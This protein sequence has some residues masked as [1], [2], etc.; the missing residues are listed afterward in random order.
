MKFITTL[1]LGILCFSTP[2]FGQKTATLLGSILDK[3]TQEA[4]IGATIKIDGTDLGATT[5]VDGRFQIPNISPKTYSMTATYLGYVPLTKFNIVLSVGNDSQLNFELSP[6]SK[7]L[8]E[9]VISVNK[10]TRVANIET[11]LSIQNLSVEEIRSNPGGNFDISKVVQVLPGIGAGAGGG[12]ERNDL[13]I[14]GGGPSENVYYLDGVEIPVINHFATQ[15]SAGGPAGILNVSFLEDVTLSTSAFNARYDNALSGVLQFKQRDGNP[16]QV[17][18]N[19]RLSGTET[20]LTLE[21]PLSKNGKTTFLASA[22]RSYLQFLFKLIDLPIRPD[23][24]DFQYKITHK[25]NAKTTFYS[26]GVGAID[27]FYF[28]PA[29]KTTPENLYLLNAVPSNNQWNYTQGFALKR[30]VEDGFWNLTLSRNMLDTQF[31]RFEDNYKSDQKDE[32]K[33]VLKIESQEIENKLRFDLNKYVG[34]WKYSVGVV[35]QFVKY[36]NTSFIKIRPEIKDSMG[37]IVQPAVSVNFASAIDFVKYGLFG[38]ANRTFWGEKVAVSLGLRTDGNSFTD[39]G[40]KIGKRISPRASASFAFAENWK[41]NASAGRYFKVAPYTM[42]G[43]KDEMGAFFNKNLPYLQSDHLVGG[44]EFVPTSSLRLTIEGFLK[45]YKNY[46]VSVRDGISLANLGS[47]Y[48]IF[49]NEP[50]LGTGNGN[51]FGVEFFIQQ[52]LKKRLFYTLSYTIFRSKFSGNDRKLVASAWDNRH[53]ISGILGY[54]LPKNWEIGLKY[55]FQG[56]VPTT[57]FDLAASQINYQISG[58]GIRDYS[59]LNTN[60]LRPFSA[61]D[62]RIDKKWNFRR[63]SLDLFLDIQNLLNQKS[64]GYAN[65]TFQRNAD[66]SGFETTNGLPLAQNGSNAKPLV[67][68]N[69]N[70]MILPSLGV[71]FEF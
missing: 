68:D 7:N 9:V 28:A 14:R 13:V 43:F 11:P 31:D 53:L 10:S 70:G 27:K 2:V 3:N 34:N 32:A 47:D 39:D 38:Q 1:F 64:A 15:G 57:P 63:T 46:P 48:G 69:L 18:G 59:K 50:V 24:W 30:L 41:I 42:L 58:Q 40:N 36:N 29:R 55:R 49:G 26:L 45:K 61:L 37:Q 20:A 12:G 33:R 54:K 6:D 16:N 60:R 19:A 66:N 67:L 4:L 17:Q 21:G 25:I 51:A 56:G 23:Y 35:G 44:F 65:Y 62:L 8:S 5:D 52:K 71:I 22:R